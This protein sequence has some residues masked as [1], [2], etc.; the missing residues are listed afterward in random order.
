[1]SF[2]YCL[3]LYSSPD[4]RSVAFSGHLSGSSKVRFALIAAFRIF[5][6]DV[7]RPVGLG[8]NWFA[9]LV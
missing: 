3:L 7:E 8:E 2:G 9:V 6:V 1:M 5:K 4:I